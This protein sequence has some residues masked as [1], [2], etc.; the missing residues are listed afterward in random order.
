[1]EIAFKKGGTYGAWFY[2]LIE[3]YKQEA[4]MGAKILFQAITP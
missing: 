2:L 4:P 3:G 1:M